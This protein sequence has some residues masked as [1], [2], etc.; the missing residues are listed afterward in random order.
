MLYYAD[1]NE[2][3][4]TDAEKIQAAVADAVRCGTRK[5][6]VPPY[7]KVRGENRWV[8]EKAV[9][10]PSDITLII[11]N[12]YLVQADGIFDNMFV[13]EN[14]RKPE[15]RRLSGTQQNIRIEGIGNAVLD[16][17]RY[18]GLHEHVSEK[19]G[20]P[21]ISRNNTILFSGVDGFTVKNLRI[22]NQRWWALC[23]LFCRNGHLANIDFAADFTFVHP[24]GVRREFPPEGDYAVKYNSIYVKNADGIDLRSG[25]HNILIENI[26]GYTEDDSIAL[27]ALAGRTEE[28]YRV[29][30]ETDTDIHNVIIR[31]I[32]TK[33]ICS[34]VRLLNQSGKKLYNILID[35]VFD[36][37][38]D[39][40]YASVL[41]SMNAGFT[42]R[43]GDR[44]LYG[45]CQSTPDE[46][47]GI[48]VRNVVLRTPTAFSVCG[49]LSDSTIENIRCYDGG[50]WKPDLAAA[51][52]ERVKIEDRE[53]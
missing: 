3:T 5:V 33:T 9:E 44:Y 24:D 7:N 14:L 48:T 30:D 50:A 42:V 22:K 8:I 15:G 21:H 51:T 49:G 35:G 39:E 17:G 2:Y 27:T 34:N 6:I 10:L 41:S 36:A 38:H 46:T 4:G 31:D 26:T 12:A 20:F 28:L 16:G 1:P 23:F 37:P 13:N 47:R 52:L 19:D 29:E 18:N 43:I 40:P 45:S 32:R 53:E 25:C 11:D